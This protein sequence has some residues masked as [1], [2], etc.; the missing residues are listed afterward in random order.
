MY[1]NEIS[2]I[3]SNCD[4]KSYV[5]DPKLSLSLAIKDLNESMGKLD[6][7]LKSVAAWCC[8]NNLLINPDKIKV[9][10]FG[11]RQA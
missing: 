5:N 6:A 8:S 10:L 4:T 7:D 1:I 3:C 11:S 9:L 2:N